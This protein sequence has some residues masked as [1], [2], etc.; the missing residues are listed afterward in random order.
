MR[1]GSQGRAAM[2]LSSDWR[3][4]YYGPRFGYVS[5]A[6]GVHQNRRTFRCNYRLRGRQ[7]EVR[8]RHLPRRQA[9]SR[10][11]ARAAPAPL[12]PKR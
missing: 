4:A 5:Y 11:S 6:T 7:K 10:V 3:G 8:E 12:R 2:R 9:S 1:L